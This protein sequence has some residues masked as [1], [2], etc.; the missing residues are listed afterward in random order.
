MNSSFLLPVTSKAK[1]C[2]KMHGVNC[3]LAFHLFLCLA[4]VSEDRL[5]IHYDIK[6]DNVLAEDGYMDGWMVACCTET[7]V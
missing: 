5:Q 3:G 2:Y 1:E 6:Y 4:Q 7:C